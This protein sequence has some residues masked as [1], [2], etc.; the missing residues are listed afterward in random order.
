MPYKNKE[1][2]KEYMKKYM[3]QY[4]VK[5]PKK[6]PNL[7]RQRENQRKWYKNNPEKMKEVNRRKR[8]NNPEYYKLYYKNWAKNNLEKIKEYNR[9]R[10]RNRSEEYKVWRNGYMRE[11]KKNRRRTDLRFNLN[12]IMGKSILR[13]LKNNKNRL[14][15][16]N[17]VGYNLKNLIKRLRETM[18]KGYNWNDF[19]WSRLHIDHMIPVRAFIFNSPEDEEFKQCWSLCNLRLLPAKE[20]RVKHDKI[21]NPILLGLLITYNQNTCLEGFLGKG[22]E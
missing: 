9:N 20:N 4:F 2:R 14:H 7:E 19:L 11:Y 1:D 3:R 21:T 13:C 5:T 16:E 10:N 12:Y 17:F 6:N 15:W 8:E 18:P 22:V